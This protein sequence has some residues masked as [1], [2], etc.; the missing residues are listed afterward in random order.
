MQ[1]PAMISF[2]SFPAANQAVDDS[3]SIGYMFVINKR[4]DAPMSAPDK[5]A[6][7]ASRPS[8]TPAA[9]RQPQTYPSPIHPDEQ[10]RRR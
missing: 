6:I 5:L 10:K 7:L 1:A 2:L 8:L 4:I 9:A 3:S